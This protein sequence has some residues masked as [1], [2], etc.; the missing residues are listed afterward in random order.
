MGRSLFDFLEGV[1]FFGFWQES[2]AILICDRTS[3]LEGV[4]VNLEEWSS[5]IQFSILNPQP[6]VGS[7]PFDLKSIVP[8]VQ[9]VKPFSLESAQIAGSHLRKR[10]LNDLC[11]GHGKTQTLPSSA[12][13]VQQSTKLAP[14]PASAHNQ[15]PT[16]V[17]FRA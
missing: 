6:T 9:I 2:V 7:R 13:R 4:C 8:P 11:K 17:P 10:A 16:I 3:V 1:C 15:V 12:T 14:C 5:K